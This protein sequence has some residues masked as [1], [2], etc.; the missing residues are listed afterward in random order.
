M[1]ITFHGAA[2]IVTGSCY[3]CDTGKTKF[4]VDCGMFQGPKEIVKMNYLP[5][6]FDPK[7][8]SFVLLTHAHID[9]SGLLPKLVKH[10]F[11]GK[12]YTTRATKDLC[13]IMLEDS[14]AVQSEKLKRSNRRRLRKGQKSRELL[15]DFSDVQKT[16]KLLTGLNYNKK[17]SIGDVDVVFKKA[18]HILGSSIIEVFAN[19]EKIVFSGDVGQGSALILDNPAT[20]SEADYLLLEST[21]GDRL[22]V[23]ADKRLKKLARVINE[24]H[25]KGGKLLIPVFAI[26]RT[27]EL[28]FSLEELYKK[29]MIPRQK[30]FLDSPLAIKATEIF[31]KHPQAYSSKIKF[32]FPGFQ[33]TPS[34]NDSMQINYYDKPAIIMA[35]SGMCD[36]GRIRHHIKHQIWNPQN[37]ILFVGYQATGTLGG[38]IK[39]GEKI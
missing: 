11:K 24:T 4:L 8:I 30:V 22:H 15:Y 6:R 28:I 31:K 19:G 32:N 2:K 12:I 34:F 25:E 1:K 23:Q 10:G 33:A 7:K 16:M 5:F 26:E 39:S 38:V 21:Y 3:L 17:N 36:A 18:G 14:V 13:K 29:K 37:S 27:Q 35:G 20:I 9:H